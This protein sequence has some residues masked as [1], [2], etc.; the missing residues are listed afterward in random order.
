MLY[1]SGESI[2]GDA[3][4]NFAE[5]GAVVTSFGFNVFFSLEDTHGHVASFGR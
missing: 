3:E 5:I 1:D 2:F 4:S